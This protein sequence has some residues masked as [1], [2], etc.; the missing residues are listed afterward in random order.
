MSSRL[1]NNVHDL[2]ADYPGYSYPVSNITYHLP[3]SPHPEDRDAVAK[4][5]FQR[6]MDSYDENE[7]MADAFEAEMVKR[8]Q[9]ARDRK[10][11]ERMARA[12]RQRQAKEEKQNNKKK[13]KNHNKAVSSSTT[14][15]T[16]TTPTPPPGSLSVAALAQAFHPRHGRFPAAATAG[17]TTNTAV[18]YHHP[19]MAMG[20]EHRTSID[21][22]RSRQSSVG[23]LHSS[24]GGLCSSV[25]RA[26]SAHEGEARM[27]ES[28]LSLASDAYSPPPLFLHGQSHPQDRSLSSSPILP[29]TPSP[30]LNPSDTTA[31]G[32]VEPVSTAADFPTSSTTAMTTAPKSSSSLPATS[33]SS[34]TSPSSAT[35]NN[36]SLS[37]HFSTATSPP[38]PTGGSTLPM[39]NKRKQAI[40]VHPSVI[41]RIPGITFRI[42]PDL[43]QHLQVEI[44]KSVEDYQMTTAKEASPAAQEVP[45]G[46]HGIGLHT[47]MET[48]TIDQQDAASSLQQQQFQA[49]QDLHK[50]RQSISSSR[51][52]Y[53]S[54]YLPEDAISY[55]DPYL[56][57]HR[58]VSPH[59]LPLNAAPN[60]TTSNTRYHPYQRHSRNGS[61]GSEYN[62]S[63][64]TPTNPRSR[65]NSTTNIWAP[66]APSCA[67]LAM[68]FSDVVA[69]RATLPLSWDNF[70]TRD[71][72]VNKIIGKNGRD[73]EQLEQV[74]QE[75][76]A[77]HQAAAQQEANEEFQQDDREET[78]HRQER[79]PSTAVKESGD[80]SRKRKKSLPLTPPPTAPV[81]A[82]RTTGSRATRSRTTHPTADGRPSR[83]G[84]TDLVE[85]Y[86]DIERIL[87]EKRQKKRAEQRR[88]DSQSRGVSEATTEG[89]YDMEFDME[90]PRI[91]EDIDTDD[92]SALLRGYSETH[93]KRTATKPPSPPHSRQATP[94][95]AEHG[96]TLQHHA[97]LGSNLSRT[98]PATPT[99]AAGRHDTT[100][101]STATSGGK[102][103]ARARS[104]SSTILT[105]AKTNF[106][107]SALEMIEAKRRQSIAKKKASTVQS[108]TPAPATNRQDNQQH[109]DEQQQQQQANH[110]LEQEIANETAQKKMAPNS[111][112]P[113]SSKLLPGRVLRK[114]RAPKSYD[115]SDHDTTAEK[116]SGQGQDGALTFDPDCSS[117]RLEISDV[118]RALW[119]QEYQAGEIH[120]NAKTW[121]RTAILCSSCRTQ[122]RCHGLRCTQCFY[123]PVW[124]PET[125]PAPAPTSAIAEGSTTASVDT[126]TPAATAPVAASGSSVMPKP[127]GTCKRCKAG[128]W[129]QEF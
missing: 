30:R 79:K 28:R 109:D 129:L 113:K 25:A 46:S 80:A 115:G 19:L 34:P 9:A 76:V 97:H 62:I 122:Y 51:H 33:S 53:A 85:G 111:N 99:R 26:A 107:E 36:T 118:D 83:G 61:L 59:A 70:S 44:L 73:F 40:P 81:P 82:Q 60:T 105:D 126:V 74:V 41:R 87:K 52:S 120:L 75:T 42:Q 88:R 3:A 20:P 1:S 127:G 27:V 123:V 84:A 48:T 65:S 22:G 116:N 15:T 55:D 94:A 103:R 11:Q 125:S 17:A 50:V 69:A 112:I 8:E 68:L 54:L 95:K 4:R 110:Q 100:A 86:D 31:F 2:S 16:P 119:N 66:Y 89:D 45:L 128:T 78:P 58:E 56:R 72:Q 10:A 64:Q 96:T 77:R 106:F 49:S 91:K 38:P 18:G 108:V 32:F 23:S 117:C 114:A 6:I 63:L 92:R 47:N 43:D 57:D 13:G 67:G 12:E 5:A 102:T 101:E 7:R 37:S 35:F 98:P 21:S 14:S 29:L 121:G 24:N 39:R 71:C 90:H 93:S 104:F 124:N